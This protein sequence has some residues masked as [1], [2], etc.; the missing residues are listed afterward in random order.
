MREAGVG[1]CEPA[2]RGA[3]SRGRPW[4]PPF[5]PE[6]PPQVGNSSTFADRIKPG[7][8]AFSRWREATDPPP[9]TDSPPRRPRGEAGVECD[10]GFSSLLSNSVPCKFDRRKHWEKKKSPRRPLGRRSS[11]PLRDYTLKDCAPQS[12]LSRRSG[13]RGHSVC[14]VRNASNYLLSN[15]RVTV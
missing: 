13:S 14:L 10:L 15:P 8:N 2:E 9:D 5:V 1:V 6:L 3:W 11:S 4:P 7:L 12:S